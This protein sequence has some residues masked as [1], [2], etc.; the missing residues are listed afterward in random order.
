[1]KYKQFRSWCNERAADGCWAMRDA[2]VCARVIEIVNKKPVWIRERTWR[3]LDNIYGIV[4]NIVEP[5]NRKIREAQ[6]GEKA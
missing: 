5:T 4:Q 1:M 3:K 6:G 2:I